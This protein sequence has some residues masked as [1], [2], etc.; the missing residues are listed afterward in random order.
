MSSFGPK[1]AEPAPKGDGSPLVTIERVVAAFTPV[2]AAVSGWLTT[3][4][5]TNVPGVTVP[6]GDVTAL[7]VAGATAAILGAVTWLVGRSGWTRH[8][9]AVKQDLT[10]VEGTVRKVLADQ[11][12][13]ATAL[14]SIEGYLRAHEDNIIKAIEDKVGASPTAEQVVQ[15]LIAA[16]QGGGGSTPAPVAGQG[17]AQAQ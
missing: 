9:A 4:V 13:L 16:A 6:R 8:V 12:Q 17:A 5:G 1:T 7:F 3:V 14:S 15:N 10:S 2:F 11:P